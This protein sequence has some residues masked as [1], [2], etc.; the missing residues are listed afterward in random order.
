M[1]EI[2]MDGYRSQFD[3]VSSSDTPVNVLDQHFSSSESEKTNG[4]IETISTN[5][6]NKIWAEK[7]IKRRKISA[8]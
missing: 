1:Q 4:T 2:A 7:D 5:S 3:M 6:R 8:F